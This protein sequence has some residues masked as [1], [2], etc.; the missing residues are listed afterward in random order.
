MKKIAVVLQREAYYQ[1]QVVRGKVYLVLDRPVAARCVKLEVVGVES[2]SITFSTGKHSRTYTEQNHIIKKDIILHTPKNKGSPELEPGKYN[3]K[4]EFAIPDKA[5]PSYKGKS[6]WVKYWVKA[7][8][9]VPLWL[10]IVDKKVYYVYR[11]KDAIKRY[12]R[13]IQLQSENYLESQDDKPGFHIELEKA[14]YA[15]G[16]RLTGLMTFSNVNNT[17][18]RGVRLLLYGVEYAQASHLTEIL[19]TRE[20][21]IK[22]IPQNIKEADT[23]R[24]SF[25][26]PKDISSSYEGRYSHYRWAFEARLDL[27]LKTDVK[28]KCSLVI[29]K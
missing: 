11:R 6:A 9:D 5:L 25:V 4:F 10:D 2:T 13:P 17:K 1:G 12:K 19:R 20:H 27:H 8:I 3:F 26:I 28:A 23:K 21:V 22:L 15:A 24:F 16:E 14:G 18:L 7:R 29:I